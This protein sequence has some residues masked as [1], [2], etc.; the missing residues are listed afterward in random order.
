MTQRVQ[1][2][3]TSFDGKTPLTMD[4]HNLSPVMTDATHH[5][6]HSGRHF[7]IDNFTDIT[8]SATIN[9][10]LVTP[11]STMR[12]YFL[13]EFDFEAE[14]TLYFFEGTTT[15]ANGT[16][17]PVFNSDRNSTTTNTVLAYSAP[18]ITSDGTQIVAHKTGSGKQTGGGGREERELILKPNTK[19]LF[20]IVNDSTSANWFDYGVTWVERIPGTQYNLVK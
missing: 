15:S 2:I 17:I 18:T 13:F 8:G 3:P 11:N 20:R 4:T 5:E 16:P 14:A 12:C 7:F 9:Y 6:I 1:T 10:L 19:Y